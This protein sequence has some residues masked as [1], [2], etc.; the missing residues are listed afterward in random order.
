MSEIT[1]QVGLTLDGLTREF[2]IITHNLANSSTAGYK[3]RC[4]T[5]SKSLAAQGVVTTTESGGEV[6]LKTTVDFSQGSSVETGRKLD[7]ALWGK[8]FFVI[9]TP[10]GPLYTRSGMFRLDRNNQIVDTA[11]RI[12][13][14]EGGPI[15]IP[16]NV[17][18]SQVYVSSDGGI[19][20]GGKRAGKFRLVDFEESEKELIASGFNCFQAPEDTVPKTAENLV[21]RQGFQEGSNVKLVDELVDMM[22]VSRLYEANMKFILAKQD[23]TKSII[24]VAMG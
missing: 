17:G 1:T 24:G 18:L 6:D 12:V 2:D 8:G 16:P 20:A 9:E 23:T 15:S 14:G 13:A 11:G 3:R 7:F 21:V 4:N 19:S 5:V 22:M 10:E